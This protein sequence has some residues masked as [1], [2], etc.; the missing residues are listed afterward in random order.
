MMWYGRA[1]FAA[2][3][4]DLT[5]SAVLMT[6]SFDEETMP[7]WESIYTVTSFFAGAS[8]DCTYYEYKPVSRKVAAR[9]IINL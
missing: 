2:S 1:N 9:P 4:E 5:R 3:D 7:A 6:L 8:D